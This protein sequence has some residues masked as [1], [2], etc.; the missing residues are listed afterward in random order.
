MLMTRIMPC[1]LV[2]DGRLV[3]TVRFRNPAYVG[4]PINAIK[5][6]NGK[7]VD[8]LIVVDITATT[9]GEGPPMA[10]IEQMASECFMPMCY[11]GGV[12]A[13]EQIQ[14]IF[15][16]GVEKVAINSYAAENGAFIRS[17]AEEF[18]SQSIVVSIDCRR[19][20]FGK[21]VV[22]THGGRR[23]TGMNPVD[24]ARRAEDCGA[25]EILL[26]SIDRDGTWSGYDLE[27]V[28]SV[29]DVVRVP[30]IA[31]GGAGCIADFGHVVREAGASAAAAGSMVVY[32]GEGL[33][34]LIK[35]PTRDE[36]RAV[37][38]WAGRVARPGDA[39]SCV[40]AA[41]VPCTAGA[42]VPDQE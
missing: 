24:A 18:G 33:G 23:A 22:R 32:Q 29:T 20:L 7:E 34:V 1:L 11:G 13:L 3:K 36:L 15:H 21:Y 12:R 41:P 14:A 2:Q 25:G 9:S 5:I 37:L 35:F 19:K 30:V 6:Y 4:D 38:P 26:N 28:R 27:L 16:L 39:G 42:P 10:L 17:A 8:E 31:V 40:C